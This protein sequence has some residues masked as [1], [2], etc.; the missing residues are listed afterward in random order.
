MPRGPTGGENS[1]GGPF[2]EGSSTVVGQGTD[3]SVRSPFTPA[4][5]LLGLGVAAFASFLQPLSVS[6]H[7]QSPGAPGNEKPRAAAPP[8]LELRMGLEQLRNPYWYEQHGQPKEAKDFWDKDYWEKALNQWADEGYNAVLYWV[9]PWTQTSWQA[10]LIRHK[11]FP[12]ARELSPEQADKVIAHVGWIFHRA[13]ELGLKNFLFTYQVATTVAF[14]K[15][16]GLDK[17][18]PLSASVELRHN[19]KGQMGP[20]FGV[21]NEATRA[22]TEAAVAELFQTYEDLD[23]LDGGMGEAL[24]GKRSGWYRRQWPRAEALRAQTDLA[25]DELDDAAGRLPGRRCPTRL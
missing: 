25:G 23:G 7:G 11:A 4:F 22:F 17:K 21:R 13:H 15:A 20:A 24:P 6:S 3:R 16:H 19:M 5:F 18:L 8:A 12:E 9:E 10:F 14:A 2:L 1:L